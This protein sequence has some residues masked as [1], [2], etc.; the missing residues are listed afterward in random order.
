MLTYAGT[1]T[2]NLGG[3]AKR[4]VELKNFIFGYQA[5]ETWNF[6]QI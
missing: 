5:F 6:A 2:K 3:G 4:C 1:F